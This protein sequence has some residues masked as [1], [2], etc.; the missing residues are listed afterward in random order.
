MSLQVKWMV[1]LI[2]ARPARPD[3]F[4]LD[5]RMHLWSTGRSGM[6][7]VGGIGPTGGFL[8]VSLTSLQQACSHGSIR[9]L[10]GM[11]QQRERR[12]EVR[13]GEGEREKPL[14]A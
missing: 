10:R 3:W 12:G 4:W 6:A 2:W 5:T 7:L 14:G 1:L 9:I 13:R 8:H 11:V